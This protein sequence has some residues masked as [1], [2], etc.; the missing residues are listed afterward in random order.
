MDLGNARVQILRFEERGSRILPGEG[1]HSFG[2]WCAL[3]LQN[4]LQPQ[5]A[6]VPDKIAHRGHFSLSPFP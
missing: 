4:T 2:R 1:G 5:I 6:A 3:R